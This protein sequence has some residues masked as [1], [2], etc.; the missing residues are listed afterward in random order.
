MG[1]RVLMTSF[2]I[3]WW[4]FCTATK[5]NVVVVEDPSHQPA[6]MHHLTIDFWMDTGLDVEEVGC[7][8]K[9]FDS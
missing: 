3:L 2:V 6:S 1:S 5:P 9:S 4:S 7:M 8:V